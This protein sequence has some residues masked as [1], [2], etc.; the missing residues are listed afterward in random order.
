MSA[1]RFADV[2]RDVP[3]HDEALPADDAARQRLLRLLATGECRLGRAAIAAIAAEGAPGARRNLRL[4]VEGAV[5]VEL[6]D[7]PLYLAAAIW[8]GEDR[9]GLWRA[10]AAH[11]TL[12]ERVVGYGLTLLGGEHGDPQAAWRPFGAWVFGRPEGWA[13]LRS[14]LAGSARAARLLAEREAGAASWARPFVALTWLAG[15][16]R[17]LEFETLL[18][19]A[20][21]HGGWFT[22]LRARGALAEVAR[23]RADAHRQAAA[24]EPPAPAYPDLIPLSQFDDVPMPGERRPPSAGN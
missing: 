23:L 2:R 3:V 19:L 4:D 21:S 17:Q 24:V 12:A 22:R 6:A 18:Q 5:A 16:E 8:D 13:R 20:A 10:L 11:P 1:D 15:H 9:R 14:R 7:R